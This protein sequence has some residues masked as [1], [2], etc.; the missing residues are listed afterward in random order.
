MKMSDFDTIKQNINEASDTDL[1]LEQKTELLAL[2][3]TLKELA[4][5]AENSNA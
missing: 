1:T 5:A 2:Q 4:K 3:D